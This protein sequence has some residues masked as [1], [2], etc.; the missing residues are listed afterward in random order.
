MIPLSLLSHHADGPLPAR[1][2]AFD[3]DLLLLIVTSNSRVRVHWLDSTGRASE[4][5]RT[6]ALTRYLLFGSYPGDAFLSS[7]YVW[8]SL[9]GS[10][11]RARGQAETGS[12][13]RARGQA[14]TGF[15]D[16][17]QHGQGLPESGRLLLLE[18][19]KQPQ[20]LKAP[21]LP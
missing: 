21:R 18:A 5:G 10:L 8:T 19:Q 3:C 4:D 7:R 12:L 16:S 20:A 1:W 11:D 2:P 6:F 17:P 15:W 13:D 14:E 9:S